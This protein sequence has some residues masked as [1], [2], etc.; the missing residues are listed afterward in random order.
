MRMKTFL[1]V[2]GLIFCISGFVLYLRGSKTC[3]QHE[4]ENLGS[5]TRRISPESS[6]E[7]VWYNTQSFS[8]LASNLTLDVKVDAPD[9]ELLLH[10]LNES[11]FQKWEQNQDL[12]QSLVSKIVID[13]FVLSI[14]LV[15]DETY[16]FVGKNP[17]N[18]TVDARL[19]LLLS[20]D[21]L[22]FDYTFLPLYVFLFI[23][24]MTICLILRKEFSSRFDKFVKR[25]SLPVYREYGK[26]EEDA[27]S[28]RLL[29]D[30]VLRVKRLAKYLILTLL[31]VIFI[32]FLYEAF[33]IASLM[34]K[35]QV[36]KPEYNLLIIDLLIRNSVLRIFAILPLLVGTPIILLIIFPRLSDLSDLVKSILGL[37]KR[38][39]RKQLQISSRMYRNLVT[40]AFSHHFLVGIAFLTF[41]FIL[42]LHS[43]LGK[44]QI[45]N[46]AFLALSAVGLG[47][48]EGYIIWSGF[49]KGC[50]EHGIGKSA[51]DRFIKLSIVDCLVEWSLA[52][53]FV[54]ILLL[55]TVSDFWT[56]MARLI[57]FEP[58][59]FLKP[60][61]ILID[62]SSAQFGAY[63]GIFTIVLAMALA[64]FLFFV[65]FPFLHKMGLRGVANAVLVFSFTYATECFILW[66]LEGML[67]D[68][69]HPIGIVAPTIAAIIAW[70]AQNKYEKTIKKRLP[71]K[72]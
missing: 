33:P 46:A 48:W 72:P 1:F 34:V 9:R 35:G 58:I 14:E 62:I 64:G 69:I 26:T 55:F 60:V 54:A 11:Q 24:G 61:P 49:H 2:L 10:V 57:V 70:I 66:V 45:V 23:A 37:E 28:V 71:R 38:R 5:W 15:E 59:A 52:I 16:H 21:F 3:I 44:M 30:S 29:Y 68:I 7:I 25:W 53:A 36:A 32:Y 65:L 22:R 8:Y 17:T 4:S 47:I 42:I 13:E 43:P 41:S 6:R 63:V 51:A 40:A 50:R 56:S 19:S 18:A 39:S 67:S 27:E 31:G 20:G 12:N